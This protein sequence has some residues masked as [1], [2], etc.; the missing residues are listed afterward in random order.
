M[1]SGYKRVGAC[2]RGLSVP[3]R[4]RPASDRSVDLHVGELVATI[5]PALFERMLENLVVVAFRFTDAGTPVSVSVA[6]TPEGTLI[7]VDYRG[8]R[9]PEEL[10]EQIF[11]PFDQGMNI[12]HNPRIGAGLHLVAGFAELHGGR[13]WVEDREGGG[14]SFRVL[15]PETS[16]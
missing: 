16:A 11:E 6:P 8:P 15:L 3:V 9:V 5:D 1:A 7:T 10:K 14:S 13:A 4:I 2:A 12:A